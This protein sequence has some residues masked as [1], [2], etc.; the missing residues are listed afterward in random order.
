MYIQQ[1]LPQPHTVALAEYDK[2]PSSAERDMFFNDV[3]A[4]FCHDLEAH[5]ERNGARYAIAIPPWRTPNTLA[6]A[7]RSTDGAIAQHW[8]GGEFMVFVTG[9][10]N[11]QQIHNKID[12]FLV[13][14]LQPTTAHHRFRTLV[15]HPGVLNQV[16]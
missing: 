12:V 1:L 15:M 2:L 9:L 14:P 10:E 7:F 4:P 8:T 6:V 5:G 3:Q 16:P 11:K 13:F